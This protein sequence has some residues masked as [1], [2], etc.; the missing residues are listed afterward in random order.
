MVTLP[1]GVLQKGCVRFTPALDEKRAAL[2]GLAM[3]EALRVAFSLEEPA[4]PAG[5]F[6]HDP[7]GEF[8]VWWS[9]ALEKTPAITAWSGGPRARALSARGAEKI[10]RAQLA[11]YSRANISSAVSHDWTRDE[12]SFGAYSFARVNNYFSHRE[13]SRPI[14]RTLFFAG[15]AA[16]LDGETAT[17][18]GALRSGELAAKNIF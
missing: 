17:V 10:A 16:F 1:L 5:A 4:A 6:L 15:E 9:S 3:G 13:L 7:A 8:R 14:S 12:F 18:E 2:E 11:R